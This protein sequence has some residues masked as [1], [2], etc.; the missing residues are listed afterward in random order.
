MTESVIAAHTHPSIANVIHKQFVLGNLPFSG[1]HLNLQGIYTIA[2]L[3]QIIVVY[4]VKIS[5]TGLLRKLFRFCIVEIL[6]RSNAILK[7]I[8]NVSKNQERIL[9]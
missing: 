8:A 5:V 9:E 4:F 1:F 3:A 6:Y 7:Y 2:L